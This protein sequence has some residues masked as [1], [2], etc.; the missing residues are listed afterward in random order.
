MAE[1]MKCVLLDLVRKKSDGG[2][3]WEK[4]KTLQDV[5]LA[6]ASSKS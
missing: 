5:F 2:F 4:T 6:I 3:S 1:R